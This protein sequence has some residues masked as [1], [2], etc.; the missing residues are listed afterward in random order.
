MALEKNQSPF[1]DSAD[2]KDLQ[3]NFIVKPFIA[4]KFREKNFLRPGD[5]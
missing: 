3:I 1:S 4:L 5:R 2:R